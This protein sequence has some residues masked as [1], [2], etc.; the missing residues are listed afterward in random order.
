MPTHWVAHHCIFIIR[1]NI[2]TGSLF[3]L[4]G[5]S[6][7]HCR[8]QFLFAQ[9]FFFYHRATWKN[10]P[11]AFPMH[12]SPNGFLLPLALR[13]FVFY[14][15]LFATLIWKNMI[16]KKKQNKQGNFQ[17]SAVFW[18]QENTTLYW[19][20]LKKLFSPCFAQ[21]DPRK[22]CKF[23]SPDKRCCSTKPGQHEWELSNSDTLIVKTCLW[24]LS[25]SAS[26][27]G[28]QASNRQFLKL[29]RRHVG[30]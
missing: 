13:P 5:G 19:T 27:L 9:W 24:H 7:F 1:T 25:W 20:M 26:T 30:T 17:I 8:Q 3:L 11:A 2:T 12:V 16:E 29:S 22:K 23:S 14:V 6:F 4:I 10:H 18:T 28:K 21:S 15:E